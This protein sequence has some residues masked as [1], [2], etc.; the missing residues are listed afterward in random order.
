[1]GLAFAEQRRTAQCA[2]AEDTNYRYK[3]IIIFSD[4]RRQH[5]EPL[6]QQPVKSEI[7]A[8]MSAACTNAKNEGVLDLLRFWLW[9]GS[10]NA[11]QELR[12]VAE[13]RTSRSRKS[14]QLVT[15]FNQIGTQ[16]SRLRVAK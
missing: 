1:M 8:R 11:A 5:I 4:R 15:V 9:R 6:E 12:L 7:D 3:K 13:H 10:E 16:M 14:D 2:P